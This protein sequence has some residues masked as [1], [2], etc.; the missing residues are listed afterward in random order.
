MLKSLII[1]FESPTPHP[2]R[3]NRP[4]PPPTRSVLP[5]LTDL[6]FQGIC[7]YLEVLAA[8]IDAPLLRFDRFKIVFFNQLVFDIPQTI[9]FFGHLD[10]FRTSS[11]TFRFNTSFTF[12]PEVIFFPSDMPPGPLT[13]IDQSCSWHIKC[14]TL[15]GQLFSL[16]QICSQIRSFRSSVESLVIESNVMPGIEID[17][18]LWL[19]LF[20]SFPSVQSLEIP[21]T[22][23]LSIAAALQTHA[24]E[25]AAEVFPSLH[26][27]SI[28]GRMSDESAPQDTQSFVTARQQCGRPVAVSRRPM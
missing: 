21:V 17:P 4:L 16:V 2:E 18:T 28:V 24:G 27:L 5:A 9:R 8:R 10:S 25:L 23:E 19:Q 14:N 7:E 1:Q 22:L 15:D 26:S 13:V 11:L 20:H 12:Y 3:R 6:G